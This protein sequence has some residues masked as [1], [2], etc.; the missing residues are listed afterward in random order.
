MRD[1][2]LIGW[3]KTTTMIIEN[4]NVDVSQPRRGAKIIASALLCYLETRR[5]EM[6]VENKICMA[7]RI[8]HSSDNTGR[9]NER[10]YHPFRVAVPHHI[11][12][13]NHT[14]R[15]SGLRTIHP[16]MVETIVEAPNIN[17]TQPRRGVRIIDDAIQVEQKTRRVDKII[18]KNDVG[19]FKPR[20]A[21]RIIDEAIQVE[22]KTR[23]VDKIIE[24]NDVG[25]FKSRRGEMIIAQNE[26]MRQKTRRVDIDKNDMNAQMYRLPDDKNIEPMIIKNTTP[27]GLFE[28]HS[29]DDYNHNIP[30][31]LRTTIHQKRTMNQ[32]R[33]LSDRIIVNYIETKSKK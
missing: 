28:N 10:Q 8:L 5:I 9:Y 33:K 14:I 20:R 25:I 1:I 15:P 16:S 12:R 3:I 31:G 13:Y 29:S 22:Q 7:N 4:K 26:L 2:Y 6:I 21:A 32:T 17:T 24:N 18:E 30:L 27:L 19:I 23:R 11:M